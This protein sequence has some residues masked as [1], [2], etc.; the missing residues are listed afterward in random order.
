MRTRAGTRV[1]LRRREP[2]PWSVTAHTHMC[3]A[4]ARNPW[5]RFQGSDCTCTQL[6]VCCRSRGLRPRCRKPQAVLFV[7]FVHLLSHRGLFHRVIECSY[8]CCC[9]EVCF[10]VK[11]SVVTATATVCGLSK[12]CVVTHT[13]VCGVV[14][15]ACGR[16]REP[17]VSDVAHTHMCVSEAQSPVSRFRFVVFVSG[18]S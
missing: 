8:I 3:V 7:M 17:V 16:S 5:S 6:P 13:R 12:R 10:R 18:V 14:V 9:A 15:I 2:R 11:E 1:H 4:E